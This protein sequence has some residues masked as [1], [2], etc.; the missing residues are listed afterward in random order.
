MCCNDLWFLETE[1]PCAPARI[2]LVR[3]G[4]N[5]LELLWTNV[6]SGQCHALLYW[7]LLPYMARQGSEFITR[8]YVHDSS[9]YVFLPPP[10]DNYLLQIQP[11]NFNSKPKVDSST[12]EPATPSNK[13]DAEDGGACVVAPA[14][15]QKEV[16]PQW[17]D[18]DVVKGTQYTVTGYTIKMD[19][20]Q[21]QHQEVCTCV[22]GFVQDLN[23]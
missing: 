6:S 18:V 22:R 5:S 15:G 3:A 19:I 21:D 13:T 17:Y 1:K 2:Q 7:Q 10:A 9:P 20:P 14:T 23:D 8:S 12:K 16:A 11:Y 4:T